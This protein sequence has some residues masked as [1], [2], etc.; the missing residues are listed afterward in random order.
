MADPL[1]KLNAT[2]STSPYWRDFDWS[3]FPYFITFGY[4]VIVVRT[5]IHILWTVLFKY[6]Q[7]PQY[8]I[9]KTFEKQQ[10]FCYK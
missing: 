3:D 6:I 8:F 7:R 1:Q 2:I 9:D 5:L 10:D 4:G